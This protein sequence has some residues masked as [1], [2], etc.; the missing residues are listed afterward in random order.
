MGVRSAWKGPITMGMFSFNVKLLTPGSE[1]DTEFNQLHV[2]TTMID[3]KLVTVPHDPARVR[4][5]K[6]C[7][8]CGA[9]GL[10]KDT[11]VKG[12]EVPG[13]GFVWFT[14]DELETLPLP[15]GRAINIEAFDKA[16]MH[17][18]RAA[19]G[20]YVMP[21]TGSEKPF[22]L[23]REVLKTTGLVAIGKMA[24]NV[25]E[26]LVVLEPDPTG[27]PCLIARQVFWGDEVF[28]VEEVPTFK[29]N[30]LFNDK[31]LDMATQIVTM[32]QQDGA[33]DSV[34]D[35]T[36]EAVDA[37]VLAKVEKREISVPAPSKVESGDI[38]ELLRLTLRE[39]Q[40]KA[41]A[42]KPELVA[43]AVATK[44]PE[45]PKKKGKK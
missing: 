4:N 43:A 16:S 35:A 40:E 12:V 34:A 23:F 3:G 10:D 29:S 33:L 31:E 39:K 44:E 11:I 27:A 36:K 9:K 6:T 45:K 24:V 32:M 8:S 7:E 25:K 28:P 13:Q 17:P 5:V 37:L 20:Y 30:F 41:K 2:G 42:P 19:K 21:D 15:S 38:M 18:L 1:H 14:K 22:A 26:H